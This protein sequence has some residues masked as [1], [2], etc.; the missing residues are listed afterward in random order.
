MNA[1]V[2]WQVQLLNWLFQEE[3]IDIIPAVKIGI[4]KADEL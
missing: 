2:G 1:A 3:I 4:Y